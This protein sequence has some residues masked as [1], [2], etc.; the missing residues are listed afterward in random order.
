MGEGGEPRGLSAGWG[1]AGTRQLEAG[2][3]R[4]GAGFNQ[5]DE[6]KGRQEGQDAKAKP[7]IQVPNNLLVK[8]VLKR[9]FS[10]SLPPLDPKSEAPRRTMRLSWEAWGS[11]AAPRIGLH[12]QR[13]ELSEEGGEALNGRDRSR[14]NGLRLFGEQDGVICIDYAIAEREPALPLHSPCPV[15]WCL[16]HPNDTLDH[17]S[18]KRMTHATANPSPRSSVGGVLPFSLAL[19]SSISFSVLVLRDRQESNPAS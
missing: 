10:P 9:P 1:V 13:K 16:M 4:C 5:E 2:R 15:R 12:P 7:D 19:F 11:P 8:E 3:G 17:S 6:R 18:G 14:A